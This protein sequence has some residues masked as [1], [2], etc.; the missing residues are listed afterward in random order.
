MGIIS[1]SD[2]GM[3]LAWSTLHRLRRLLV[4]LGLRLRCALLRLLS[5][6][7]AAGCHALQRSLLLERNLT[8]K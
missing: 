3:T 4:Y 8:T 6:L 7:L 5:V 2:I 1:H